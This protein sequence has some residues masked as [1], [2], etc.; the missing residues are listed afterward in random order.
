MSEFLASNMKGPVTIEFGSDDKVCIE[1]P[2]FGDIDRRIVQRLIER[3]G[4]CPSAVVIQNPDTDKTVRVPLLSGFSGAYP[5][6][7]EVLVTIASH[8]GVAMKAGLTL[9]LVKRDGTTEPF[10]ITQNSVSQSPFAEET[11]NEAIVDAG[12]D[13]TPMKKSFF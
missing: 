1:N 8:L 5:V 2:S 3:A 13:Y 7:E 9:S 11:A 10:T 6:Q 4:M 12:V